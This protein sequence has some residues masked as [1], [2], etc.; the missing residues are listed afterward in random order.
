MN[1]QFLFTTILFLIFVAGTFHF[2]TPKSSIPLFLIYVYFIF[3]SD[4]SDSLNNKEYKDKNSERFAPEIITSSKDKKSQSN[5]II[6]EPIKPTFEPKP[7]TFELENKKNSDS[8]KN[9]KKIVKPKKIKKEKTNEEKSN[10]IS[11]SEL[12]LKDIKICKNINQRNPI[13][14]DSIFPNNVDSL[15]CFS[16]INNPGDK[17]EIKHA[18]YYENRLMTQV[19]YNIKKSNTYRSWTKKTILPSQVGSWRVDIHDNNGTIIGSKKFKIV[20]I[21]N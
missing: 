18:W 5:D 15:Y 4:N 8:K 20:Q 16:R 10:L 17:K 2:K 12:V 11:G 9:S 21:E 14:V 7:L 1:T 6:I 3:I 13:G 19:R